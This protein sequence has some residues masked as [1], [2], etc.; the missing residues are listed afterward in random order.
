MCRTTCGITIR[1]KEPG[2]SDLR[3]A[4]SVPCRPCRPVCLSPMTLL[5]LAA[6]SVGPSVLF[7]GAS[8]AEGPE[9]PPRRWTSVGMGGG[10]AMFYPAGSPHDPDLLFV[11][12]DMGGFYRSQDGGF[13]W[14]MLDWRS[15]EHS[16][17]PVFH[18]THANVIYACPWEGDQ[19]KI[20][21]DRGVTWTTV[22]GGRRTPWSGD[23]LLTLAID[24]GNPQLLLLA[25]QNGLY[26][27]TDG[28]RRWASIAG[29]PPG[30]FGIHIDQTSPPGQRVCI[31]ARPQGV[32]RS[33]DGATTWTPA[34]RGLPWAGLR[35]FSG[36]SDANSGRITLFCTVPSRRVNG[37]FV[38]GVYRSLDRANSWQSA[39][40]SGI[41]TALGQHPY[42]ASDIDQY[43]FLGQPE[44][45][46]DTVYVTNRGTGYHPPH[47]YTVYRSDD[48]GNSWRDCFF[49]DPRFD[50][51][52]TEVG[53]LFYDRVRDF[54]ADALGFAVNPR[55]PDHA[56]YANY[57]ELLTTSDGG[58]YW[59]Q[60]Y[61]KRASGQ[62]TPGKQQ[63]WMSIGLEDTTCWH[64]VIDPGDSR[65]H[66]ICYSDIG[67]VRSTDGG[68]T[69]MSADRGIPWRN[70]VYQIACDPNASGRLWAACSNQHDIP[71]WQSAAGPT[72]PG[73]VCRSDDHGQTW[74][75]LGKGLPRAPATTILL[76]AQ[77]PPE[78]PVLYVGMYGHGVYKS[79]DGG[80]TWRGHSNGITPV[81]NRQVVSIRQHPD[82]TLYCS[83]AG[84]RPGAG[85]TEPLAGGLFQSTN[86]GRSWARISPPAA[87][88]PVDFAVDPVD[89]RYL[90]LAA[91]GGFGH[92]GGL[93]ATNDGGRS[94]RRSVPQFNRT[95]GRSFDAYSVV[96]HPLDSRIVYL[97]STTHGMFLSPD[98]GVSWL[99]L[100]AP[101]A[102]P[103]RRCTRIFWDPSDDRKAY[104]TTFGGGVWVGRDPAAE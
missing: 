81:A 104:I 58:R 87:F 37:Q 14:Q 77:S 49:N 57:A 53:W 97:F 21:L 17:T 25:G 50:G 92:E 70:T 44:H 11:S 72:G 24:R 86:G 78:A 95:Q 9:G 96:L 103:F 35:A 82:G 51:N 31:G 63:R 22:G 48:G 2:V 79:T 40:G 56:Y 99:E 26:R 66:Y 64:Y 54:G 16:R 12:S 15:I 91:M 98:R 33:I 5:V 6:L 73:G 85:V 84:R 100:R 38:G 71:M 76:D 52:N 93:Y 62:G 45:L 7:K 94:W 89:R 75:V 46:P 65:Y 32:F 29:A 68:H 74:K 59:Y 10:G 42:G 83:V 88:R 60:V 13:S 27:S 43:H 102:P 23:T 41:H 47:H 8:A 55:L 61:S 80:E 69:W 34:S 67:L 30:L 20:S 18:P 39:M 4:D 19:L 1:P 36:G 90:Y 28:G 3:A 101:M